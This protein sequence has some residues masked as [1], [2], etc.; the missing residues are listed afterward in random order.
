[1]A[2]PEG[3]P[4]FEI[5]PELHARMTMIARKLRKESTPSE[6]ILWNELRAK[7]LNGIKFRRQQPIGV[8]VV[9]FYNSDYRL[10]IEVDGA[11]HDFQQEADRERQE[12]LEY[13]GFY[14]LRVKADT[15]ENN[16]P[17]AMKTIR[18]TI[19]ALRSSP[20]QNRRGVRGEV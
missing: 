20:L 3:L 18:E 12:I 5:S 4:R 1:M 2:I 19:F 15:V 9:D 13:L 16:L 17:I 6:K 11:I 7:K 8:F 14:V 10:I